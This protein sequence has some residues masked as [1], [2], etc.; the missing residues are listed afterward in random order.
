MDSDDNIVY[1]YGFSAFISIVIGIINAIF[2]KILVVLTQM[3]KHICMTN[4]FLSYSIKLTILTFFSN[5]LIPYLSSSRFK[6]K[7]SHDILVTNCFTMFLSNS[8]IIPITWTINFEFV[9][10]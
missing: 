8:F 7:L 2:Q 6:D 4:Y 5:V 3:E 9:L 10:K 1:R